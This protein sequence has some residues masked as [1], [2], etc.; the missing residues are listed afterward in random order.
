MRIRRDSLLRQ[1]APYHSATRGS[2]LAGSLLRVDPVGDGAGWFGP[3]GLASS[4]ARMPPA[5]SAPSTPDE[6]DTR[7]H[8]KFHRALE[9][10]AVRGGDGDRRHAFG[11][12]TDVIVARSPVSVTAATEGSL[13]VTA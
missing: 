11:V 13:E 1:L 4:A 6:L 9:P 2:R 3:L 8:R 5:A 7:R 12:P 10:V